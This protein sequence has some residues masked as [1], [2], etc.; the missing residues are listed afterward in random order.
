MNMKISAGSAAV[1]SFGGS[2]FALRDG[3]QATFLDSPLKIVA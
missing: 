2:G 1:Q 3:G